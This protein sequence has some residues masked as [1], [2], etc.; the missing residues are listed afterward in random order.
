MGWR[1]QFPIRVSLSLVA[2]GLWITGQIFADDL[3]IADQGASDY[4]IAVPSEP[5]PEEAFA[6]GEVQEY[7]NA[8][9]GAQLPIVKGADPASGKF[10][11]VAGPETP[12]TKPLLSLP[13]A[14]ALKSNKEA[15]LVVRVNDD[16]LMTGRRHAVCYAAYDFL[17]T[18]A[19]VM[20]LFPGELG[21]VVP[22]TEAL[23]VGDLSHS[24]APD[25]Q[26]RWIGRGAW[27]LR[28]RLNVN[29]TVGDRPTGVIQVFGGH[30]FAKILPPADYHDTHPEYYALVNGERRRYERLSHNNQFCTS[31]P[32]VVR[33]AAKNMIKALDENPG[34]QVVSLSPN[35][36]YGFCECD[37]CMGLD[38]KGDYSLIDVQRGRDVPYRMNILSDRIW[39]FYNQVAREVA[40]EYPDVLVKC[41]A[42]SLYTDPPADP[43]FRCEPN[44]MVQIT[45]GMCHNHPLTDPECPA[46][47]QYFRR[48]DSWAKLSNHLA[49]YEYYR[50]VAW[51]D[52]PWG[53]IHSIQDDIPYYRDHGLKL[54]FTQ[55]ADNAA[56]GFG[57]IYYV[58]ARKLWDT[59]ADAFVLLRQYCDKAYGKGAAAMYDYF[60]F[61]EDRFRETNVHVSGAAYNNILTIFTP[62]KQ[63]AANGLL[64]RAA[65]AAASARD[66]ERIARV[67]MQMDWVALA[68]RYLR[69]VREF[70]E[71]SPAVDKGWFNPQMARQ[72]PR[73]E[74]TIAPLLE[75][76]RQK[77]PVWEKNDVVRFTGN[78]YISR[79]MNPSFASNHLRTERVSDDDALIAVE[80]DKEDGVSRNREIPERMTLWIYGY[81]FDGSNKEP[82]H[83]LY[84]I[85][86]D[87]QRRAFGT[88]ATGGEGNRKVRCFVLSGVTKD[89]LADGALD[90]LV[91]NRKDGR[92]EFSLLYALYLMPEIEGMTPDR[93]TALIENHLDWVRQNAAG[94]Y[95]Y[96]FR[97]ERADEANDVKVSIPFRGL[98]KAGLS[99]IPQ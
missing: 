60:M 69:A 98:P 75:E 65:A 79:F 10:L 77:L 87:G 30:S 48:V 49:I 82:E 36:G 38:P 14:P 51:L 7:L 18:V 54:F 25:I 42:Y 80:R 55:Y 46:N 96:P 74:N 17:E 28:N 45:H 33:E 11:I 59:R 97:G 31:N 43:D 84:V 50:K 62:E 67:R 76:M 64:A 26:V 57:P 73:L 24:G 47:A 66:R 9:T 93:A 12:L 88:L 2:L 41:F 3:V 4:R 85:S 72:I 95:E 8:A 94:A 83:D 89:M 86:R 16:V 71:T 91:T 58:A 6:A 22:K 19:D 32:D 20:W 13:G 44:L 61:W 81:D 39:P 92:W 34:A 90:L 15:I 78:N 35:D 37:R 1:S 53:I 68:T 29:V 27:A 21:E 5:T 99:A 40:K 56:G 52:M 23:K 70:N 63:A